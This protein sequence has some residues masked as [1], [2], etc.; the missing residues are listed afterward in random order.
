MM[1]YQFNL[2]QYQSL[3]ESGTS[4]ARFL[5]QDVFKATSLATN[6]LQLISLSCE[7]FTTQFEL[8]LAALDVPWAS[9][10]LLRG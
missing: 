6:E 5:S 2:I 7:H 10:R 9:H 4:F 1:L 3:I 8:T